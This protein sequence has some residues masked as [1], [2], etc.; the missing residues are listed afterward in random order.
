MPVDVLEEPMQN[1]IQYIVHCLR[2]GQQV[3][4][5]LSP[6]LSYTGQRIV[7]SAVRSAAERK[8]VELLS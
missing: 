4:G 3:A 8:T 1:P 6:E 5:P 7:D 2:S